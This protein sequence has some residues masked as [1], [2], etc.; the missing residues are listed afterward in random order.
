MA[1]ELMRVEDVFDLTSMG[2]VCAPHF[3]VPRTGHFRNFSADVTIIPPGGSPF[4]VM[5]SFYLTHFNIRDV[6]VGVEKRWQIVPCLGKIAKNLVP[7]GSV[8]LCDDDVIRRLT[9]ST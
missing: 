3:P 1:V 8:I 9:V 4:V 5:A 7:V 6:S 2:L